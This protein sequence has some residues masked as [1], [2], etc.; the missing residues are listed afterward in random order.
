MNNKTL[1]TALLVTTRCLPRCF[2][3]RNWFCTL[4]FSGFLLQSGWQATELNAAYPLVQG[5]ELY[6]LGYSVEALGTGGAVLGLDAS[7][8]LFVDNAAAPATLLRKDFSLNAFVRGTERSSFALS[9]VHPTAFGVFGASFYGSVP[10][11]A[12]NADGVIPASDDD[13][14][15]YFAVTGNFSKRLSKTL[16][17]GMNLAIAYNAL[18]ADAASTVRER[19]SGVE[20]PVGV[21]IDAALI[22]LPA[23][24]V[25]SP[26]GF[27]FRRVR[28]GIAVRE[29]GLVPFSRS[30]TATWLL[31]ETIDPLLL[32][33]G[34]DFLTVLPRAE[35]G[36]LAR[37]R[38]PQSGYSARLLLDIGFSYPVNFTVKGGILQTV[39]TGLVVFPE[40][41]F[42]VGG[43]YNPLVTTYFPLMGS[44]AFKFSVPETDIVLRWSWLLETERDS[45]TI[46]G[47]G[48]ALQLGFTFGYKD[49]EAPQI[50]PTIFAGEG[51]LP[52]ATL[53]LLPP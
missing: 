50:D 39:Y 46:S 24:D 47:L 32:G 5:S 19:V 8:S 22:V 17:F 49:Q 15:I 42:S 41:I 3:W 1:A 36:T 11:E 12:T 18:E 14:G 4:L 6:E 26:S 34:F 35:R 30:G 38:V 25:L 44:I 37:G 31:S 23:V 45:L 27:S 48:G 2:K 20:I 9:Y 52:A 7:G 13:F 40:F 16:A 29:L 51:V 53:E 10:I 43:F 21:N 33:L 28:Y